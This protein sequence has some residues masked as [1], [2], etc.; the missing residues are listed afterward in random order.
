[1]LP[2]PLES[3]VSMEG[4]LCGLEQVIDSKVFREITRIWVS[5]HIFRT[6]RGHSPFA[7][8]LAAGSSFEYGVDDQSGYS[9]RYSGSRVLPQRLRGEKDEAQYCHDND[10]ADCDYRK[11]KNFSES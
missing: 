9:H 8:R 6:A 11:R 1:M 5:D 7:F 4:I 3:A 2:H 10:R